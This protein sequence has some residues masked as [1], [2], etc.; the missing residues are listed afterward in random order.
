I[1]AC[2][3]K[4]LATARLHAAGLPVPRTV[5][6]EGVDAALEAFAA[7]G[8]DVVLKPLFGSEGR[9][10]LRLDTLALAERVL[11]L[12]APLGAVLYL[13]EFLPHRHDY[14]GLVL[15]GRVL[16]AMRRSAPDHDF[17]ANVSV[18]GR[19]EAFELPDA[20][21]DLAVRAAA[22]V[23]APFAGVDLL[24]GRDGEPLVVEVNSNPGFQALQQTTAVCIPTAVVDYLAAAEF[25]QSTSL[26]PTAGLS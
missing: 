11:S 6:C 4:Y 15:G 3:D 25:M 7:L 26:P 10:I 14:R 20:W 23:G 9:G 18:G 8:G 5:A 19:F 12:V 24:T 13:Q 22:A 21:R 2:V 1:E 17:R 16:A